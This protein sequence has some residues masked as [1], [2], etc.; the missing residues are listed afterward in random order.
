MK[1]KQI[2]IL[3]ALVAIIGAV[4][5]FV[6]RHSQSEWSE[7]AAPAGA[8]VVDFPVN[9]V[10]RVTLHGPNGQIDLAKKN[11]IWVV[12]QKADYPANFER[13]STLIRNLWELHPVQELKVGPSQY[14]RLEL[15]E[16]A[17]TAASVSPA[18]SASPGAPSASPAATGEKAG[19]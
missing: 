12:E 17:G 2:V 14:S 7:S 10:A 5:F 3:L 6:N 9:D 13:V 1:G 19:T 8:K 15:V 4:E 11:N 16:P 18:A